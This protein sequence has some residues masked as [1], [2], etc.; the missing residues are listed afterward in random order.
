MNHNVH[1]ISHFGYIIPP[2]SCGETFARGKITDTPWVNVK[3]MVESEQSNCKY[4][5]VITNQDMKKEVPFA[6]SQGI[7]ISSI[8]DL[9]EEIYPV[10]CWD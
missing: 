4:C 3:T 6:T 5:E 2:V 10:C 7:F 1:T 9:A 8:R